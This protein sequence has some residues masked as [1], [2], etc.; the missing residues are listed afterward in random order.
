[1]GDPLFIRAGRGIVATRHAEGL[2]EPIRRLLEELKGLSGSEVFN[3]GQAT[4]RF[5]IAANDLQRDLLLPP[6]MREIAD[7]APG[8]ELRIIPAGM[9]A[10]EL[11][12]DN[13]CDL[14][15][16]PFPPAG[17]DVLQKR[18]L[19]DQVVCFYDP[20]RRGPP[21]DEAEYLTSRHITL[22]FGFDERNPVEELMRERGIER[23]LTLSVP[24]YSGVP[25]FMRDSDL[26]AT[27]PSLLRL[28]LMGGFAWT[29]L[30]F[31]FDDKIS[32]FMVWHRRNHL[33]PAQRWLRNQVERSAAQ[34]AERLA[35]AP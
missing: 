9:P 13:R 4:V 21:R 3:P 26:L 17:P 2:R 20:G 28:N 11:M 6:L 35:T 30:P 5:A 14:V 29:P 15:L 23:R 16:T 31:A 10:L 25:P 8:I 1:L 18:L 22:H 24:N 7:G 34:L 32:I 12:R 19:D 33:D 27:L